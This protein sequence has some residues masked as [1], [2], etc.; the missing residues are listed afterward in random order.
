M[1]SNGSLER[2]DGAAQPPDARILHLEPS[3][4]RLGPDLKCS[5]WRVL[6]APRVVLAGLERCR[7]GVSQGIWCAP[8]PRI[9]PGDP[10]G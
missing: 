4:A 5:I 10:Q 1:V 6:I 2:P 3:V 8:S 7:H 9:T